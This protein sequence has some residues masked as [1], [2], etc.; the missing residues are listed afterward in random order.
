MTSQTRSLESATRKKID[1]I[2][3]SLNW[4][5]DEEKRNCNVFT[6]RAKTK[7][8]S[9]KFKGNFPDYVLYESETENPIAIIE[10]KEKR[11]KP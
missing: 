6:G 4:K 1:A 7:E 8:Q 2:L 10:A 11:G 3:N 9:K 5:T